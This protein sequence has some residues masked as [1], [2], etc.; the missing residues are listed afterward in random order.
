LVDELHLGELHHELAIDRRDVEVEAGQV[1]VHRELGHVHLVLDRAHAA[2][3]GLGLQQVL[4][5]PA[6]VVQAGVTAL[7]CEVGPRAGHAVQTQLLEFNHHVTH[8]RSPRLHRW[9]AGCRS[10][11]CWPAAAS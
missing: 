10:E 1:A 7:L 5:E 11:P 4:D 3:D 8:G 2:V 6:R 9:P